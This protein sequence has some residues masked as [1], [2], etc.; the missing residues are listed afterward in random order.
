MQWQPNGE[1]KTVARIKAN[2]VAQLVIID[3]EAN[4]LFFDGSEG[5]RFWRINRARWFAEMHKSGHTIKFGITWRSDAPW[6]DCDCG[7]LWAS[8]AAF[9]G[10]LDKEG[11]GRRIEE[12]RFEPY[13]Y[14]YKNKNAHAT[15]RAA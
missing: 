10:M 7:Q 12:I 5:D 14:N 2:V 3:G 11:R 8:P 1:D 6:P 15:F 13:R 9:Q 4:C